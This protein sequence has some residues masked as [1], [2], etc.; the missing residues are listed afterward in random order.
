MMIISKGKKS[1]LPLLSLS[2][3]ATIMYPLDNYNSFLTD[4]PASILFH[5]QTFNPDEQEWSF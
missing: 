3:Q 5:L 4:F 2:F 1:N